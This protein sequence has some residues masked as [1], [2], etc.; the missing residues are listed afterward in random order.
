MS[1]FRRLPDGWGAAEPTSDPDDHTTSAPIKH[2]TVSVRDHPRPP[3]AP[4]EEVD[5]PEGRHFSTDRTFAAAHRGSGTGSGWASI[6]PEVFHSCSVALRRMGDSDITSVAVTSTSRGEGRTTV[7][8]GLAAAASMGLGLKTI[9]LDLD[10]EHGSIDQVTSVGAG[11]GVIEFLYREA[12]V[13]DCIQPVDDLVAVVRAGLP[14]D[15]AGLTA[16]MGRLTD[17]IQQ[18]RQRCDVLIADLPPLSAGITSARL[19]DLFQSVTLVV[20]AGGVAVPHIEETALVL[21][22]RPFVILNGTAAPPWSRIRNLLSTPMTEILVSKP[23]TISIEPSQVRRQT[24]PADP[25]IAGARPD[26]P[27]GV[28]KS[29]VRRN[30]ASLL[31]SQVATLVVSLATAAI[32]PKRLGPTTFGVF[33]FAGAFLGFFLL[34]SSLGSTPFLVKTIAREPAQ[35]GRYIFNAIAMKVVWGGILAGTAIAAAHL[36]GFPSQTVLIIS[37]GSIGLVLSAVADILSAG[38]QGT[39]RFGKL[40]LWAAIQQYVTVGIAIGLLLDGKG[41]VVYTLALACSPIVSILANGYQ[42]WPEIGARNHID[43]RLWKRIGVGGLPFCLWNAI[44]LIYGSI[45][46]LMLQQMSGSKTVGW[47]TLAYSWVGIPVFFPAL[48]VSVVFPSLSNTALSTSSDFSRTVNRALQLAVFVGTPMAI[49]IA[50]TAGNIIDFLH[51]DSFHQAIPLIQILALHIPIVSMDMILATALTAKDRQKAWLVVGCVAVV[52]NPTLNLI[53][54]PFANHRYG[55]GAIG[56]SVVTVATEVVMMIGA[57]YLRPKGVL[58]RA[59][60][61]FL[62]RTVVAGLTMIPPVILAARAPFAVKV[63]I[64]AAAF[65]VACVVLRLVPVRASRHGLQQLLRS[66]RER[67]NPEPV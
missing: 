15:R 39:E 5:E 46:I 33:S 40:A 51:Y 31:L 43:L 6:R 42:L 41:V 52:F 12:T 8:V 22:Q 67:G 2:L 19:A 45:D 47:Y 16:R 17:L 64:G 50:L 14:R 55:N 62:L 53:A 59:T 63:I 35:L 48:L 26:P 61:S 36:L 25:R 54:I 28:F 13:E 60:R 18:L 7:A 10:L 37:V 11:P 49:G 32:V 23:H 21:T 30:F 44:L 1:A 24:G 56:A 20:R 3:T 58:D 57:I 65:A 27:A 4:P 66:L 38:L 29:K 9:L 34:L